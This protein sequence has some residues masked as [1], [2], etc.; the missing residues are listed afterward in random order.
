MKFVCDRATL[1]DA[2]TMTG[3]VVATRTA[4]PVLACIRFT[5]RDG[6]LSLAATD[7]EIG[8]SVPVASVSISVEGEALIPADKLNQIVRASEDSTLSIEVQK[9]VATI[10]GQDSTFKIFGFDPKD[11]PGVQSF[12]AGK[13]DLETNAATLGRLIQRDQRRARRPHGQEAAAGRDRR[14]A[15]GPRPR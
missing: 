2:L 10:K 14:P 1:L 12:P 5:A 8:L 4:V 7:G 11:F 15:A 3:G 9:N 13:V 6:V